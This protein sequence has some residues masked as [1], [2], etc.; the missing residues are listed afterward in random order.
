MVAACTTT[1][2]STARSRPRTTPTTRSGSPPEVLDPEVDLLVALAAGGRVLEFAIGTGRAA[3]P[4]ADRGVDV[5]GIELSQ[6]M[7]S[8]L[9]AKPGGDDITVVIGDMA[10]ARVPGEFAVVYLGFN[11]IM[12]LLTQAEQVACFENAARHLRPGG[13]F[14]VDVVV[15]QI[16]RL[17]PGERHAVFD[18]SEEHIGIDEYEL[19]EQRSYSI[20]ARPG[21]PI[22]R[23]PFRYVWPSELD[24]MARNRRDAAPASLGR[25]R[26]KPVHLD[27][28]TPRL[29]VGTTGRIASAPMSLKFGAFLAPHHPLGESP[30]PP[31]AARPRPRRTPRPAR[32]RRVLVR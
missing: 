16:Q 7:V 26:P 28:R 12:N 4:L 31:V 14:V 21:R 3:L 5:S 8:E 10:I 32:L 2:S 20:H 25:L 23:T 24:L 18:A 17:A 30:T 15:P 29:G 6:A 27:E 1:A 11:T 9:R 19:A 13:V 22:T